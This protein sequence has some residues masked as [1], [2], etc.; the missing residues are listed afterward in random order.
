M[1]GKSDNKKRPGSPRT[2]HLTSLKKW[3]GP[4]SQQILCVPTVGLR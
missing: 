4:H 1:T 2:R 3:L